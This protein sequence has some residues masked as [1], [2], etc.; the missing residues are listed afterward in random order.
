MSWCHR[1]FK[2][3]CNCNLKRTPKGK[4]G[5]IYFF[6]N[7]QSVFFDIFFC[8]LFVFF[9]FC[10]YIILTRDLF[11]LLLIIVFNCNFFASLARVYTKHIANLIYISFN[12]YVVITIY[13]SLF[14]SL[15][16]FFSFTSISLAFI[17]QHQLILYIFFIL[18]RVLLLLSIYKGVNVFSFSSLLPS[19][20]LA[21]ISQH[22]D[23]FSFSTCSAVFRALLRVSLKKSHTH[24][25][26]QD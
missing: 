1:I 22:L 18:I 7:T 4:F 6:T 12:T 8:I 11:L 21:F 13:N 14:V 24:T 19:I 23:D 2:I 26:T 10:L 20:S 16:F 17:S 3:C 15:F 25:R 5:G 9:F